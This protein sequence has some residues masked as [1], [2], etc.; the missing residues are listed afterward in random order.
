MEE[1]R[2]EGSIPFPD[3]SLC[4]AKVGLFSFTV[5]LLIML[6]SGATH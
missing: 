4:F 3:S 1:K 5:N 2:E 6:V